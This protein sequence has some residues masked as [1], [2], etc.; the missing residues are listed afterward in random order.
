MSRAL[1]YTPLLL[2]VPDDSYGLKKNICLIEF[3][4]IGAAVCLLEQHPITLI[5]E[6][7]LH[8]LFQQPSQWEKDFSRDFTHE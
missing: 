4:K 6:S 8:S 7:W 5:E 2:Y 1:S 3:M